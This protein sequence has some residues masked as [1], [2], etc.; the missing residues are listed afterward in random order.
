MIKPLI[1]RVLLI[2]S[3]AEL[4]KATALLTQMGSTDNCHDDRGFPCRL[5][6]T[7]EGE[8]YTAIPLNDEDPIK[9]NTT[10]SELEEL[11]AQ[12]QEEQEEE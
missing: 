2:N 9:V 12:E 6:T 11:A 4:R 8:Y 7:G 3:K 5:I 10:L 1:D